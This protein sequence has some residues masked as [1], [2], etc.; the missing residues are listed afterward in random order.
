MYK[1][2]LCIFANC[3]IVLVTNPREEVMGSSRQSYR[4]VRVDRITD[5][6]FPAGEKKGLG[7]AKHIADRETAKRLPKGDRFVVLS[8]KGKL[9]YASDL[10]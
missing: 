9:V 4:L 1:L 10:S 3:C 7:E 2:I 5:D 8:E 6:V